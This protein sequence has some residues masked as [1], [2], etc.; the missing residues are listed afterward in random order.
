MAR[1]ADAVRNRVPSRLRDE[2]YSRGATKWWLRRWIRNEHLGVLEHFDQV[3]GLEDADRLEEF[4]PRLG[5]N[6][7]LPELIPPHLHW[8][9]GKGLRV[10]Q[11][12]GQF[13]PYLVRI[14]HRP[15]RSYLEIGVQHG[16]SFITTVEYLRQQGHVMERALAVDLYRG[17]V[18]TRYVKTRPFAEQVALDSAGAEFR[19]LARGQIWDL[20]L[21]DGDHSFEGCSTDFE[22]L[23]GCAE[24]IAFHDIVDSPS[25]AVGRVWKMVR[26]AHA[27]TYR[28]VEFTAQYP[29][30]AGDRTYL[31]I[32][33]AIRRRP[34]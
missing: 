26:R 22:T 31:G 4:L 11:Y 3:S 17:P 14:A 5:L 33:L 21:I 34:L 16:G 12:P 9:L 27:D 15:V 7:D 10:W 24:M 2:L 6:A 23:H 32:G 25:P 28:F 29:E 19:A 20:A 1:V 18:I 8:A 30:V 13:A